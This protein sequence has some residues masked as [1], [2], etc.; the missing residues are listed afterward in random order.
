MTD[1]TVL[2]VTGMDTTADAVIHELYSRGVP[3]ARFD[4]GDFP[5]AV[6]FA[7]EFGKDIAGRLETPSRSVD[8]AR[9]RSLYYRRPTFSEFGDLDPG[10]AQFA[11]AQARFGFS[12]TLQCLPDCLYVNHPRK[13]AA[14]E[15][16]PAQLETAARLGFC[17]P[18]TIV[19]N[20]QNAITAFAKT[21]GPIVY[22]PVTWSGYIRGDTAYGLYVRE[23]DPAE[24]NET[25][26]TTAHLFQA[27]VDKIADVRV[28][29]VGAEV[30]CVR[31]TS[32]L[33]DWRENYDLV[34]SY[35][36]I[37]PPE[38]MSGLLRAYLDHWGLVYGCFDFGID[39][40]GTWWWYECNPAGE[41][42]WLQH[43][44]GQPIAS[45]FAD[46]LEGGVT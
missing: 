45:A 32:P 1:T 44:T 8:L 27:K 21:H 13:I 15:W 16:K 29:V 46:V 19:S 41:W 28:T 37:D 4:L 23:V 7:A 30:F 25:V 38:G 40:H 22:K 43:H 6:S 31:I 24:L 26:T 17:V 11:V 2:V 36:V 34:E 35:T 3:V 20:E 10:D 18:P 33:T 14:A 12:G 5:A 9:V 42:G 39:R